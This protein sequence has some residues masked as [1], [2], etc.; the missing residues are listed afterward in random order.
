MTAIVVLGLRILLAG[1]LYIF[2][3]WIL[4]TLWQDIKQQGDLLAS[5]KKPGI[6][7]DVKLENGGEYKY[8]FHQAV[9]TIGRNTNCDISLIDEAL[10]AHHAR[11]SYHHTQWWLEDLGSKNGTLLNKSLVTV[12]TVIITDDQFKSGNTIFTVR[13]DSHEEKT[14]DKNTS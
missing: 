6:H 1:A 9:V 13:I 4:V 5:Q 12:P 11:I 14:P 2:L 10:S 7:I 3:G 8:H